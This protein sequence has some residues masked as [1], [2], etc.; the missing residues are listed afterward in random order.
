LADAKP[1]ADT[2]LIAFK[3]LVPVSRRIE[4]VPA[5]KDGAGLFAFIEPKQKVGETD[6]RASAFVAGS[7]NRFRHRVKGAVGKRVAVDDKE[8]LG[9]S[10]RVG[11]LLSPTSIHTGA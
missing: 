8:G 2:G 7:S 10:H 1:Q 6:D 11:R 4:R 3:R 5:D 9:Q